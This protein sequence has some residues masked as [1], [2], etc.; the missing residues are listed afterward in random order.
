[1]MPCRGFGQG[2]K[3][4]A[5]KKSS[6]RAAAMAKAG[7]TKAAGVKVAAPV[8]A[9]RE[10][11]VV[12]KSGRTR[13]PAK[14]PGAPDL[15]KGR[16]KG[17]SDLWGSV[18]FPLKR[19]LSPHGQVTAVSMMKDEGPYV[20]E[21]VAHHLAVGFSDL[22]VYTNDCSDGTDDMLI[23]LE[24]LGLAHHRRNTIPEGIKPQPS[25]LNHAQDEPVVLNSDWVMVFD[26]DEFLSIRYGDGTL[27]DLI[28]AVKALDA[29]GIVVTWRIFGSGGVV[30][31]SRAP[32]TEQYLMAAPTTW[33]KGWGVKTLFAFDADYW[34]LGIHRP[35]MKTRHIKTE[36]P[37]RVKW[38]TGSGGVM[39][40]YF[41]FR[42]WRSIT[43]TIGYDW[44][45]LNHYAV[46]SVD[47]YA[48]R[49]LRG[50][51]NNKKDKYNSDYWS[52]QDRNEVRDDTMLRYTARRTEIIA[53]LLSD[54]VLNRLHFAA[55][56]DVES[57]LA[58]I[59]TTDAYRELVQ[60]LAAAS[61]VPISQIVAKPPQARD[62]V[63][64]AALMTEVEKQRG[65]TAK[66][67][68]LDG[69]PQPP[70]DAV[71]MG[72]YVPGLPDVAD[73]F[74]GNWVVNHGLL[75]PADFRVF[76]PHALHMI[77]AG[78][79]E[80]GLA[81]RLPGVLPKAAAVLEIGSAVGFLGLH[82]A[83]V[84]PDLTLTLQE[85]NLSLRTTM[86]RIMA[87]NE[88]AF[89]ER[90]S[91][92]QTQLGDAPANGVLALAQEVR[93]QVLLLADPRLTADRLTDLLAR[94]PGPQPEQVILYGRLLEIHHASLGP[95]EALLA[96]LGYQPGLGFDPNIARG[97]VRPPDTD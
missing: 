96:R 41:K 95:V 32:V 18:D 13:T 27:D 79:F 86:Q 54:P 83:R 31:W 61:A 68:R 52:L 36:F 11:S 51:V 91:L 29:N 66:A 46:K 60:G 3:M 37:D 93:P 34:K 73:D 30:D 25:A 44:V 8:R 85:E 7:Q 39:E 40:D 20:I 90:L 4:G 78:K 58:K 92:W 43:R 17:A 28:S 53:A 6:D 94:L 84:R 22:V 23:R 97:F 82:L 48:I 26:A 19:H 16:P 63:K 10:A 59:R 75:L 5:I 50:N 55:L 88:R 74:A 9:G 81:R 67:E 49:K 64:I 77:E 35:K 56:D 45:Q 24:E 1:M 87:K 33:N 70:A 72:S 14:K 71:P 47:S 42:G 12:A 80:R 62:K 15:A 38:L 69:A 76:P 65:A 57:R 2:L 89:S 21:W